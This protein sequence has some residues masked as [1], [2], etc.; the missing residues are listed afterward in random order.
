MIGRPF[1]ARLQGRGESDPCHFVSDYSMP[2]GRTTAQGQRAPDL[3]RRLRLG[4][5]FR[6]DVVAERDDRADGPLG[7]TPDQRA[8]VEDNHPYGGAERA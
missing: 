5:D 6:K 2:R 3:G 8:P 7:A 1:E 4:V